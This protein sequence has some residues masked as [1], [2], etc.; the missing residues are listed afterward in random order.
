MVPVDKD[1]RKSQIAKIVEEA[2]EVVDA[3]T[4]NGYLMF[5]A[6]D[7]M[8]VI[9]ACETA[10]REFDQSRLDYVKELVIEKNEDRGYYDARA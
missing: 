4:P 8:D 5:Y 7:L 3:P 9:H 6:E 1:T 10:L 2:S